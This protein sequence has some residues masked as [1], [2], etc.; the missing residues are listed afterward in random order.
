MGGLEILLGGL[1]FIAVGV[2][3]V[4]IKASRD[5][6]MGNKDKWKE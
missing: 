6:E 5:F 1:V 3:L 4:A 2:L